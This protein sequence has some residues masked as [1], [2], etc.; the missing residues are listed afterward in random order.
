MG[1]DR[2][3]G[4]IIMEIRKLFDKT[5]NDIMK[6]L[7]IAELEKAKNDGVLLYTNEL[8]GIGK[9]TALVDFAKKYDYGVVLITGTPNLNNLKKELNYKKIYRAY[10]LLDE[11]QKIFFRGIEK[12]IVIDEGINYEEIN[13]LERL[14]FNIITGF[15]RQLNKPFGKEVIA[16][17]KNEVRQLTKKIEI[18]RLQNDVGTYKNL[19]TAYGEILRLI[20]VTQDKIR[21]S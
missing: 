12:N 21:H 13:K 6:T 2:H 3:Q 18:A 8:R 11:E 9:T 14:G 17:L 1:D 20:E 5:T 10:D 15:T 19:I 16:T 7:L 4:V